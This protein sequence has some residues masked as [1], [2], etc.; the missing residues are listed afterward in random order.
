MKRLSLAAVAAC[1]LL[2]PTAAS[3]PAATRA[4]APTATITVHAGSSGARISP[5][6]FGL[7]FEEINHSGDGGIYAELLQNRAM[8]DN[9]PYTDPWTLEMMGHA[10]ASLDLDEHDPVNG[11]LPESL[12][13]TISRLA[14]G[15]RAGVS[16]PGY[17]G[18]AIRPRT[19]YRVSF[20][21]RSGAGFAGPLSVALESSGNAI[22]AAATVNGVG[23]RWRH[24]TLT[25]TTKP[26]LV[27]GENNH[28]VISAAH[29]GTI[30]FSLVSL[31]PPTWNNRPNGMRIDLMQDLLSL[32]P[33]FLRIPGGN[34]LEGQ[35]VDTRFIWQNTLGDLAQR[36]GHQDDAWG[37]R[38]TDGL[39]LL[40]YLE[41]CEDL[42]TTPVL[43]VYAG[44]SLS[45]SYVQP[46]HDLKPYVQDALNE[47]QYA[48]GPVST[49]WGAKRA[50]DGHP[51]PFTLQY[52]E[53]GNEDFFDR[54]GSY[55]G[56]FAQFYDAIKAAYPSIKLISTT[57]DISSR[58]PDLF[59]LHFYE[60][61]EWFAG[62][63]GYF[64]SYSRSAPKV[65]VGEYAARGSDESIGQGQATLGNAIGEAAWLTGLERNADVVRMASYAPLFQ[66]LSSY[67]WSPDLISY[68]ALNTVPSPSYYVQ[69][70]FAS[71]HGDVVAPATVSR[72]V[73]LAVVASRDDRRS[74]F[75]L[76]VVNSGSSALRCR[77]SLQGAET[78]AGSSK[79]TVLTAS[80][81]D[82]QNTLTQPRRVYPATRRIATP[83]TSFT[84]S[85]AAH[86]V[87]VL[88]FSAGARP[89]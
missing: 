26:T 80:S 11:N 66:N 73:P 38:S 12:R 84:F 48:T 81:T 32:H 85:F 4:A 28:F 72:G 31:F 19:T 36:P 56:R 5:T 42:H 55:D 27:P 16:N 23:S 45:G 83:S 78:I 60:T 9:P 21:A 47:I 8:R 34:Y 20:Y 86:S 46:G 1:L 7:M 43:A 30:W 22:L 74:T 53:I 79:V 50:A 3:A 71:N 88:Q 62:Q 37:Y 29:T 65:M 25:L 33:G 35:T 13:L 82:D 76:T 87:T 77:V 67:Q 54:S 17:Y 41:W 24:Y 63:A 14:A 39:G 51:A 68:D 58:T 69:Q 89:G 44:Y 6:L 15:D 57:T 75:Y 2:A 10:A 49:V 64:D 59:D 40:E 18:M 70:L 61:A 52:V